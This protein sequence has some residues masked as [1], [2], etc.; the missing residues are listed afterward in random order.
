MLSFAAQ[1]GVLALIRLLLGGGKSGHPQLL[2]IL[3]YFKH[4][5]IKTLFNI[6]FV[7][8]LCYE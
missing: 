4:L 6:C 7:S 3:P 8:V 5:S 1:S 2:G